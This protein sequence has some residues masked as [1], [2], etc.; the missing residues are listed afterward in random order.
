LM[1]RLLFIIL[2]SSIRVQIFFIPFREVENRRER[3]SKRNKGRSL[4]KA[5]GAFEIL[6]DILKNFAQYVNY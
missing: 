2:L 1:T 5:E 3:K 6:I 4:S